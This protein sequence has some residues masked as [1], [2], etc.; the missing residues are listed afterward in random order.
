MSRKRNYINVGGSTGTESNVTWSEIEKEKKNEKIFRLFFHLSEGENKRSV[1]T[2]RWQLSIIDRL[3]F[4]FFSIS[5]SVS[6]SI[7]AGN[8]SQ[9]RE[10]AI[11]L[12]NGRLNW[13]TEWI[14]TD[15]IDMFF[16]LSLT[17]SALIDLIATEG[18]EML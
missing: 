8:L 3:R 7:S 15:G 16:S 4:F 18:L 17:H 12:L 6:T 5:L 9:S 14:K 1:R 2:N 11:T 10:W 13:L